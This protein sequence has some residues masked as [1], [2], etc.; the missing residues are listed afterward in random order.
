MIPELRPHSTAILS[1]LN[2]TQITFGRGKQPEG[3]G[4]QDSPGLSVFVPYGILHP[5]SG[6]LDGPLGC[7]DD[8]LAGIWQVTSVGADQEQCEG[9][10]DTARTALLTQP[11]VIPGR[12]TGRMAVEVLIGARRD[13]SDVTEV[14]IATDQ[15]RLASSP[16]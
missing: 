7:P 4:W 10:A 1:V 12:F 15:Y 14:W 8:D 16:S 13:D 3:T 11:I 5:I 9:V 2:G 6:L